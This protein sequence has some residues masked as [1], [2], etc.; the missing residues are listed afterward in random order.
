MNDGYT[1][2][3]DKSRLDTRLIHDYLCN[4]SYWARGRSY[5]DV[6]TTIDNSMCFGMY[7]REERIVGFARVVTDRMAF[8]YLM[9]VFILDD[10]QG[11]GLGSYLIMR[12]FRRIKSIDHKIQEIKANEGYL[13]EI[14]RK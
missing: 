6:V 12:S 5:E 8:A 14:M 4:K 10:S 2:S 3:T 9:D 1:I 11:E 7:D 13:Q